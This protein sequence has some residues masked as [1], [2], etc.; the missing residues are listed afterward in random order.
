[1]KKAICTLGIIRKLIGKLN[2]QGF[3]N[4]F[5]GSA[6]FGILCSV[7]IVLLSKNNIEKRCRKLYEDWTAYP[8]R[9]AFILEKDL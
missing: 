1:M 7:F 4:A 9:K 5:C 8:V 3:F 2:G 6:A